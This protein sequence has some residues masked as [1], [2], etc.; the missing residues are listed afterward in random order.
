MREGG[1]PREACGVFG[2]FAPEKRDLAP[3]VYHGLFALQ[4]RGQESAG[5]AL[6]DDGLFRA[7]RD[8]G[9]VGEV[10]PAT[11]WRSWARA[12]SPWAMCATPPPAPTG[13]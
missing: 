11:S 12:T 3:M 6:N 5:I 13:S 8:A 2:V 1:K 4:H 9:L 7:H 10:F